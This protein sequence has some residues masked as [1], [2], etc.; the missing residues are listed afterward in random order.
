MKHLGFLRSMKLRLFACLML[1]G[2]V[3]VF[4][5][6]NFIMASYHS[7]IYSASR[8]AAYTRDIFTMELIMFL[9]VI[10]ISAVLSILLVRPLDRL[11][12][13]IGERSSGHTNED[14]KASHYTETRQL[15][16]AYNEMLHRVEDVDRSRLE[17]VSNV[18][19][20][21]KTPMT[22]MKVL[23]D[24][25]LMQEDVPVE[26]YRE[27]LKDIDDE[28]DREN[29]LITELLG[30][31]K[32]EQKAVPMNITTVDIGALT[33]IILKR[34]RPLAQKRDIALTLESVREVTANVDEVKM[35]MIITN[36]VDNA[37]K[38]NKEH[39]QVDVVI[40]ADHKNFTI[41]VKDTGS[42]IPADSLPHIYERFYRVDKS[43]SREIG[44]TG[45]G[46]AIVKSAVALHRGSISVQSRENEGCTFIVTIPLNYK[47]RQTG[48]TG[49]DVPA[50]AEPA[51]P[52][53]KESRD[54]SKG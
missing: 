31:A 47:Q 37:V 14:V 16:A 6:G 4:V 1:M 12:Q 15:A 2:M 41:T 36:L 23:A 35:T 34:V 42:G 11:R 5:M 26:M 27:F 50:A 3:P 45:L 19:H 13:D 10:L 49:A 51:K 40:D 43:R 33:E 25:L 30:L 18:S 38:Y 21:L 20:E 52:A 7:D 32:I 29:D 46:L 8:R 22:S 54:S 9:L 17:F 48:V 28:I 44:G 39:G 24:S 53:R